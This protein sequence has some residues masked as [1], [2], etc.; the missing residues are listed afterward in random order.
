MDV[1][2][3]R[4]RLCTQILDLYGDMTRHLHRGFPRELVDTEVTMPQFKTLSVLYNGPATMGEL[5]EYL[6]TGVSTVTGIVDRLVEHGLVVREEDRR[7]RRVVV[8]RLTAVGV[9]VVDRIILAARS[10]LGRVLDE[11]TVDDLQQLVRSCEA[12]RDG[13]RKAFGADPSCPFTGDQIRV[14]GT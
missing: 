1:T 3:E 10:R 7:D 9:E 13:A 12:L 11:L 6:G 14:G 4:E 8:G 2:N 5:A